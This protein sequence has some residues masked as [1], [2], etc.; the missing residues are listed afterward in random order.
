M[1]LENPATTTT[2]VE[3]AAKKIS[4]PAPLKDVYRSVVFGLKWLLGQVLRTPVTVTLIAVMWL[5]RAL[6]GPDPEQMWAALGMSMPFRIFDWHLFSSALSTGLHTG[7]IL[8]T[9]AALF[10][11]VPAERLL[12]SVRFTITALALHVIGVPITMIGAHIVDSTGL[13]FW[14]GALMNETL[15]TPMGW[16]LGTAALA[17]SRMPLL[18]RRRVRLILGVLV[19]AMVLYSGNLSDALAAV[20]VALGL[21]DGMT[22]RKE[23]LPLVGRHVSHR[24]GRNLVAML[25]FLVALGPV[26]AGLN[27]LADGPFSVTTAFLWE[28]A[29][30]LEY[31]QVV[32]TTDAQSEACRNAL[33]NSQFSGVG[34]VI[35]N[36]MPLI[37]QAVICWGLARGR[38]V[39]WWLAIV[40]QLVTMAIAMNQLYLTLQR[41]AAAS[42]ETLDT[43]IWIL[44]GC[45]I[46]IP[47]IICL[48]TLLATRHFFR[49]SIRLESISWFALWFVIA[50]AFSA[51][52]WILVGLSVK[53]SFRPTATVGLLLQDLPA[54]WLPPVFATMLDH[55][56]V[57]QTSLTLTLSAWVTN[58][59]WI[60]IVVALYFMLMSVPDPSA[61]RDRDRARE[62]LR[63]GSGDHL[64]WMS[65]WPDNRYWFAP[66]DRGYVAYRVRN[67]IAVTV[68]EP[69]A[70]HK[71]F[72]EAAVP[73]DTAQ[74]EA[75]HQ[76]LVAQ[77]ADE[78][79]KFASGQGWDVAW[80]SVREE[81]SQ[82]RARQRGY[83]RVR[84]AEESVLSTDAIEFKGK[85]FQNIRTARNRAK[86]EGIR[87]E[88][89]SWAET[90]PELQD[91]IIALSEE[92]VAD[93]SL[94]EMGFT[95]GGI[96]EL[97][98]PD[99]ML[100]LAV[101]EE[102]QVHGVTSW[103]PVYEYGQIVGYTLDF[104]RRNTQGFRPVIEYL[105]AEA[106]VKAAELGLQWVSLSGAPLART[107]APSSDTS[108]TSAPKPEHQELAEH[109]LDAANL[110][111]L[112]EEI[113]SVLRP[114]L[115]DQG[116]EKLGELME[117]LY[118]FRSL[119]ASK[120]KF[121]PQHHDW[122]LCYNDELALPKIGIAI[123]GCYLPDFSPRDAVKA[124]KMLATSEK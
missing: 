59:L 100:L 32:C 102:N 29:V 9:I 21:L 84:V 88:W 49:V 50:Q 61:E 5:L 28:P 41:N 112:T 27:P 117:P 56:L 114:E 53:S 95:L 64:S 76:R 79:E 48:V 33:I 92:W 54:V 99:T 118:G 35:A 70:S 62:L 25:C 68:G 123:S 77:L 47:W 38:H 86:K 24:E 18:W 73:A 101:D 111:L 58:L 16:I 34:A 75:A 37:V 108:T 8:A 81:F 94:P 113:P 107:Q 11:A 26:I 52:V 17:T 51:A 7:A 103:L 72:Q 36:L 20:A 30:S 43:H 109:T 91:R 116:L 105:L 98:D 22:V 3:P 4:L 80:Y 39:A 67:G 104:M 119:A 42:G 46:C 69:V 15:L 96:E 40:A 23:P 121:H 60:P 89:L 14:G 19:A 74:R 63:R 93:K 120:Y 106:A 57:A 12:G 45:F 122:Y 13:N 115:L 87:T 10:F 110:P 55:A 78:F 82:N 71:P 66:E 85:K 44:L 31:L 90:S 124:V 1:T 83:Y 65:V 97:Q 6:I 2:N